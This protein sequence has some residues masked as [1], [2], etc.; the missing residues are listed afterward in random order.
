[1]DEGGLVGGW[2]VVKQSRRSEG[3]EIWDGMG[4]DG[5]GW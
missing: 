1:M 4:W 2:G 3:D 5:M